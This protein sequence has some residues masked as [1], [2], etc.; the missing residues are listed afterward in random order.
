M[1]RLVAIN[2]YYDT[3]RGKNH[4]LKDVNL[5]LEKGQKIGILGRNGAGKTTLIRIL[6]G[7][8][9]PTTGYVERDMTIS[10]PLA[11]S[12]AFQQSLTGYDNLKFICRIYGKDPEE[13]LPAVEDFAELGRYMREPLKNYSA[14]MRAR[15]GFA[16]SL[17]VDFDCFL[18]DEVVAVG[19]QRFQDRCREELIVKR[20]DRSMF[21]VSHNPGFIRENC[22]IAAVLV[23]GRLVPFDDV[24]EAYHYYQ[25]HYSE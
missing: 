12:G 6:G 16:I 5:T 8:E 7:V 17:V 21:F 10:W 19:D 25:A 24:D 13:A 2:K 9:R 1:I 4:V 23:D 14:G 15:L 3:R 11:F 22:D 20:A 18:I